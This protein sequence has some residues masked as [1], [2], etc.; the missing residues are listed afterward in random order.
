MVV[1]LAWFAGLRV[2]QGWRR[3][4]TFYDLTVLLKAATGGLVTMAM[5]QYLLGPR[6]LVPRSVFLLDWGTT[7]VVL[8]ARD[9]WSS[10]SAIA[11]SLWPWRTRSGAHCRRGEM[12]VSICA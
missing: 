4:V 12:G 2:C 10:D 11:G 6:P 7:I 8:G 5:I 1:K 9:R 3:S